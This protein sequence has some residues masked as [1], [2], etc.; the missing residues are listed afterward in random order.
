M[1]KQTAVP[2]QEAVEEPPVVEPQAAGA[3]LYNPK[4]Q[5]VSAEQ[6]TQAKTAMNTTILLATTTDYTVAPAVRTGHMQSLT[7]AAKNYL[8][9]DTDWV[10]V[11]PN[12]EVVYTDT[13]FNSLYSVA[14]G[15]A[16]S[17]S[18][19]PT[20]ADPLTVQLVAFINGAAGTLDINWGDNTAHATPSV[21]VGVNP[22]ITHKYTVESYYT[23][24]VSYLVSAAIVATQVGSFQA[25][26]APPPQSIM[27]QGGTSGQQ[28]VQTASA[29]AFAQQMS[30]D[31][32]GTDT[33]DVGY[34]V[35]HPD[36]PGR[37]VAA[38]GEGVGRVG[39]YTPE[40]LADLEAQNPQAPLFDWTTGDQ[41]PNPNTGTL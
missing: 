8:M 28:S 2:K 22:A 11:G 13:Q 12:L 5:S 34:F 15:N 33:P 38:V 25:K 16:M 19:G 14:A 18:F 36:S 41:P 20:S 17:F 24:T 40:E 23:I 37:D 7:N 35:T 32:M 6:F 39:Y 10:V 1:A 27:G 4:P 31:Q 30:A 29:G 26:I 9:N 3:S 21:G